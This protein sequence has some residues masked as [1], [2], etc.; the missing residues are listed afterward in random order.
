[1][2]SARTGQWH[3]PPVDALPGD[4]LLTT[5]SAAL[6]TPTGALA[7]APAS[8]DF[9]RLQRP[10]LLVT[11]NPSSGPLLAYDANDVFAFDA[12]R[13]AWLAVPRS[14]AGPLQVQIWRT[15][16]LAIDGSTTYAYGAAAGA[17][18]TQTLPGAAVSLRANSESA[19]VSTQND[20]FAF[21]A[22]PEVLPFAQFPEFRRVQPRGADLRVSLAV[23]PAGIAVLATGAIAPT[24]V[25]FPGLGEFFLLPNG[26]AATPVLGSPLG[27]P[28]TVAFAVPLLPQ[29]LGTLVGWQAAM[30]PAQGQAYLSELAT[31][32]LL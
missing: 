28:V 31:V 30:L 16:A 8:G 14:G 21:A 17:W 9:V 24:S 5:T 22:V 19:R 29:L 6:L 3:Q 26:T 12:R 20:L 18:S 10:G 23:P 2:F 4:P 13:E 1:L 15:T 25:V 11:G 32:L 7:F 27:E